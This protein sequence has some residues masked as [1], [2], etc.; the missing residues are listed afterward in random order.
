MAFSAS[1]STVTL[2]LSVLLP[3][4]VVT[5]IVASPIAN[6]FTLPLLSTVAMLALSVD[7]VTSLLAASVGETVAVRTNS[8]PTTI[9]LVVSLSFT[10]VTFFTVF[11]GLQ[12]EKVTKTIAAMSNPKLNT[13]FI[14]NTF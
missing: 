11:A 4:F 9:D 13:F 14:K 10:P 5:V 12:D 6:P 3:S 8:P 1:A 7:Q 2:H